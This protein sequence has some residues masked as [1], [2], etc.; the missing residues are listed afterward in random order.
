MTG[1]VPY[2]DL[3]GTCQDVEGGD[4]GASLLS[5]ARAWT[6]YAETLRDAARRFHKP[7]EFWEGEAAAAVLANFEAHKKWLYQMAE[8]CEK[9]AQQAEEFASVHKAA[10]GKHIESYPDPRLPFALRKWSQKAD[11]VQAVEQLAAQNRRASQVFLE[12]LQKWQAASDAVLAEYKKK[13]NI[14]PELPEKPP[15]AFPIGPPIKPIPGPRPGPGDWDTPQTPSV[16]SVP[17]F[18]KPEMPTDEGLMDA[19]LTDALAGTPGGPHS[20]GS[21]IKPASFGGGMP[22]QPAIDPDAAARAAA[23]SRDA[24]GPGRGMGGAGAG[25]MG[26]GMPM[27]GAPGGKGKDDGQGKRTQQDEESLY[28]ED[29]AWT[30]GIIGRIRRSP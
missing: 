20:T 13:L 11:D 26:G 17:S 25:G 29:R 6:A 22:L 23:A 7:F 10:E 14:R 28:T 8:R 21:G 4:Q 19:A 18:N 3:K 15:S 16:P 24:A 2:R 9:L 5:F 30:E 12:I 1:E 27:G